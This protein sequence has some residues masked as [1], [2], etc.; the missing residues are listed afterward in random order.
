ME[1]P[2]R[3]LVGYDSGKSCI[4]I[5]KSDPSISIS[6]KV[7]TALEHARISPSKRTKRCKMIPES[8]LRRYYVIVDYR[9]II[10]DTKR[11]W[12]STNWIYE[13]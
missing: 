5:R 13:E 1:R 10:I 9:T 12:E 7:E 2:K 11:K 4:G 6:Y 3:V 8:G